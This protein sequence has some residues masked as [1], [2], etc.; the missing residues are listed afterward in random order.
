MISE[1]K[2]NSDS[3]IPEYRRRNLE[4]TL[5]QFKF[6]I[7]ERVRDS[8]FARFK[9]AIQDI[10]N[11]L[12]TSHGITQMLEDQSFPDGYLKNI[13]HRHNQSDLL[14]SPDSQ[15]NNLSFQTWDLI[16][17]YVLGDDSEGTYIF[18]EEDE[19]DAH[20][21]NDLKI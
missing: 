19:E 15:I 11:G 16:K 7:S 9:T 20:S 8:R 6:P 17:D 18:S 10:T 13:R 21:R 5:N 1:E 2:A 14:G 3:D 12:T 4:D